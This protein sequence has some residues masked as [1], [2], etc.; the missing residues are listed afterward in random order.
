MFNLEEKFGDIRQPTNKPDPVRKQVDETGA[1]GKTWKKSRG[2]RAEA[3]GGRGNR[4]SDALSGDESKH[5]KSFPRV[6]YVSN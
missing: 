2:Q 5:T 6:D 1:T 3:R 4:G